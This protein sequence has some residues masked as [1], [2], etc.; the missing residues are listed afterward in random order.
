MSFIAYC[1][2]MIL[3]QVLAQH[4]AVWAD[5]KQE[6]RRRVD[7][8]EKKFVETRNNLTKDTQEFNKVCC[9]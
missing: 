5:E 4:K 2:L 3:F 9:T 6:L 8:L 7:E 1:S